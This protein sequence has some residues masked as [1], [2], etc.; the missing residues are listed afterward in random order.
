MKT[1]TILHW[2]FLLFFSAT[3]CFCNQAFSQTESHN[4]TTYD[5]TILDQFGSLW[6]VRVS[7]PIGMFTAGS[8]DTASRPAIITMP[9]QGE[10]G[11]VNPAALQVYGPH[12]WLNQGWDGSVV[13]GNGIH[14]PILV[15]VTN[16]A[17]KY[18]SAA[19]AFSIV[20]MV[21]NRYHIKRNSV[22]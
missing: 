20:S 2:C 15:T 10:M 7:R 5:T 11:S 16:Y 1:K 19:S 22:H 9:G 8:P 21:V 17:T 18:P 3:L 6:G 12:Y 14:Y 13:L 4:F